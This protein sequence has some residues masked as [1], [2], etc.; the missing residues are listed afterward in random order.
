MASRA[1]TWPARASEPPVQ[2]SP[3]T[4]I[5]SLIVTGRPSSGRL[6]PRARARSAA[7][8]PPARPRGRTPRRRATAVDLGDPLE[9]MPRQLAG[10][11]LAA[12][13]H[14]HPAAAD[15]WPA[16]QPASLAVETV[17]GTL[18]PHLVVPVG[19]PLG[20]LGLELPPRSAPAALAP[21]ALQRRHAIADHDQVV[22]RGARSARRPRPR[23]DRRRRSA[24]T[25][26]R[27]GRAR[28][29]SSDRPR[30]RRGRSAGSGPPPGHRRTGRRRGRNTT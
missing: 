5:E 24:A 19:L 7:S 1:G 21:V 2:G 26:P 9:V 25:G 29:A 3:R 16:A 22:A 20:Q 11:T 12:R 13:E 15:G 6:S 4:S 14:R 8:A 27:V 30:R 23:R 10:A 18:D 28:P 17:N